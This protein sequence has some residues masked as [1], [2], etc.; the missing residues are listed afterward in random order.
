MD[1]ILQQ[2]KTF[3]KSI[4]NLAYGQWVLFKILINEFIALVK[5]TRVF[6]LLFAVS[7]IMLVYQIPE[8]IPGVTPR[9]SYFVLN[10]EKLMTSRNALWHL[11]NKIS[12]CVYMYC[13]WYLSPSNHKPYMKL[14]LVMQISLLVEFCLFYNA[15]WFML[16]GYKVGFSQF[17]TIFNALILTHVTCRNKPLKP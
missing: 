13:I 2:A 6:W 5:E 14:F 1:L 8:Y 7:G 10:P 15:A 4:P 17:F 12:W 3:L 11:G 16:M 9:L